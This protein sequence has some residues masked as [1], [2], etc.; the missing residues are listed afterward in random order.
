MSTNE[1]SKKFGAIGGKARAAKMSK[2]AMSEQGKRAAAAR[3]GRDLPVAEFTGILRIGDL[4]FPCAVLS[5]GETRVLTQSDF[6][7]GMGM[8][9]SGWVAANRS[10]EDRAADVPHFLGFK[11]LK[12]FIDKHLGDLQSIVVKYRT[13]GGASAIGIRATIIPK[14]CEIWMDA[15]DAGVLGSRQKK[16]AAKARMLMRALAYKAMEQL[17]DDATGFAQDRDQRDIARFIAQYVQKEFRQWM[18]TFPRSFFEQLCRL[19]GVPFPDDMRLPQYFGHLINDLV[20]DRLAPGIRDELRQLNPVVDGRRKRKN[21]Q[22]LTAAIGEPRLLHHLGRL[23]GL[24]LGYKAGE[25]NQFHAHADVVLPSFK[26]LSL[27]RQRKAKALPGSMPT[28]PSQLSLAAGPTG[29]TP[30]TTSSD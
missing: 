22:F 19:R 30:V 12:P 2:T 17:V 3:W 21:F 27:P 18:P 15:D 28:D 13:V 29:P 20:W 14:I 10:D 7:T 26:P 16:V 5:D 9:Y 6:M 1:E 11:S 24:A 8:Y 25:W 4:T 23:E